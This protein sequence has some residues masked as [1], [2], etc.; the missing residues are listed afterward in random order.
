M[1]VASHIF[2]VNV[3]G[4]LSESRVVAFDANDNTFMLLWQNTCFFKVIPMTLN[5]LYLVM[6]PMKKIRNPGKIYLLFLFIYLSVLRA[7]SS[8]GY[9][10]GLCY[11]KKCRWAY[12][13]SEGPDQPEHSYSLIRAF[14]VH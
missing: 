2:F 14:I 12:A 11:A 5:D 6:K 4:A 13:D 3:F 8:L 7:F 9:R 1:V 10:Y